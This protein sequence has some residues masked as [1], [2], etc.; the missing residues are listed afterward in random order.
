MDNRETKNDR[1]VVLLT[2][3]DI[4][5]IDKKMPEMKGLAK[6][7]LAKGCTTNSKMY[8]LI[9]DKF[10]TDCICHGISPRAQMLYDT[11]KSLYIDGKVLN[12]EAFKGTPHNDMY[13]KILA[14]CK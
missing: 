4:Y 11:V 13:L 5:V 3:E 2:I 8:D 14:T 1:M 12:P 7:T 10:E 9:V 6:R